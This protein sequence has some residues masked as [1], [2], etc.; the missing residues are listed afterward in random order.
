MS[1][2]V[3]QAAINPPT[4]ETV[5]KVLAGASG[6]G[7]LMLWIA[8]NANAI[9]AIVAFGTLIA[10]IVFSEFNRRSVE[11]SLLITRRNIEANIVDDLYRDADNDQKKMLDDLLASKRNV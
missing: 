8:N 1:D 2:Q 10:Y 4:S 5:A 7:G 6:S 9:G 11:R 3:I